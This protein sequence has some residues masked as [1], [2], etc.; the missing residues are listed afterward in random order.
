LLS[1]QLGEILELI[2]PK[3]T[4]VKVIYHLKMR[5]T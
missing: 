2:V 3:C 1:E 4:K 5:S